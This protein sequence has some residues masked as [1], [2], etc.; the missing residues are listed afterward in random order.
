M[1]AAGT[2]VQRLE[3][4]YRV[5][6]SDGG[7]R[8]GHSRKRGRTLAAFYISTLCA[9]G[10]LVGLSLA[11]TRV[12]A[13]QSYNVYVQPIFLYQFA[14]SNTCSVDC[15]G[16][17]YA[18]PSA[19]TDAYN[20]AQSVIE[21]QHGQGEQNYS[22]V[23]LVIPPNQLIVDGY[24][25]TYL[26]SVEDCPTGGSC[27]NIPDAGSINLAWT[28]P[29]NWTYGYINNGQ[30]PQLELCYPNPPRYNILPCP[31]CLG[32][33]VYPAS[34]QNI[35]PETDYQGPAVNFTRTYRSDTGRFSSIATQAFVNNSGPA[36]TA[37]ERCYAGSWSYQGQTGYYC[38]PYE[39]AYPDAGNGPQYQ[40]VTDDGRT[41]LFTG[42][43]SAITQNADIN[44]RITQITVNGAVEWQIH[45]EDD[46]IE[47]Y[48]AGG[49][50]LQKTLRGGQ[51]FTYTY[52]N[53]NT[54]AN[55][56]PQAGLLLSQSDAF[57]HTISWQ[58]SSASQLSQ[59]TDPAG[60]FYQYGYDSNGNLTS[61]LYPDGTSKTYWY[62]ESANTGGSN[63]PNALTGVTDESAVR[64]A[65]FKYSNP[66]SQALAVNTQEAGAVNSFSFSYN[67]SAY[68]TGAT[69]T[70]ATVVDP[71]GTSRTYDFAFNSNLT[72]NV[73][74][75]ETQ[76]AASGSGTAS[77]SKTYDA[78]YN[79]ASVT[80]FNGD[81]TTYLY[82]L[83]RNLE[84][85]RIEAH[86]TAQ[87][88]TV[89]TQWDANWRQPALI[90]LYSGG[91][92]TGTPLETTSFTYNG[93][94]GVSCGTG[95]AG[96]LC[97]K[98]ITDMTVTPNVSRTWSY[99]Y[100]SY[101]RML[102]AKGP[103]TDVNSTTT[104]TYYTCTTGYQCGE[105]DTIQDALGHTWTFNT[106]NAHGQ[107]LTVTDPNGVVT[108]LTYDQRLRVLSRQIGTET[109]RYSYWPTGLLKMVTLPDSSTVS[110]TYD[111]A[112]RLTAITDGTG[113]YVSYTLDNMG[114]HTA[115]S[116]YDPSGT[117]HRTH[118][119]V[120][121]ALNELYQDINSAGTAAVTTTYGYD[122]DGNLT[123]SDAPLSRN[124][125]NQY[126]ALNRLT[127]ITDPNSGVTQLGYD[128]NDNLASVIDPRTL[129]TSYTHNGFGDVI[130]VVSPDTGKTVSTYDSGGD[131]KTTTDARSDLATYSYDA[132]NRVTQVAYSD[133]TINYTYDTGTNGK[134]HLTGASDASHSMSWTYDTLG[135][136]NGKGQTVG[137]LT[138]SVGYS[139]T[140]SDLITLVTP[141]GQTVTYTYTNHRITSIK[142]GS[143]TLLS[144]VT[145]DP[146]GPA[147]GWTWGNNT[148]S[149]R[150][151]TEDG[152]PNQ[153]TTA[154][155]INGYTEDNA[156]RITGISDSGLSSNTFT[157]GYDLL[158][159]VNSA[160]SSA[161][162]RG[163]QYD[164]NGN[165][166]LETGSV[167]YTP[168]ISPINNQVA[169][170][171]GGLVR[172][173]AYD[174]AGNTT[175]YGNNVYAFN[176]RGRM[177]S[178]TVSGSQTTYIYN[179]L[180]QLVQKS[181]STGATNLVYD[182]AGH[183]LGEYSTSGALIQETIWMED[184]PVA[185][186]RP[187]GS[188]ISIYY[189]HTDHLGTPRKV[190]QPSNNTLAWR[191]DP[192]TYGSVS[193]NQNPGGLGTFV[194][195]LR[196]PGQYYQTET[197]LFYNYFRDYDPQTGRYLESDP[198]GLY[199]G[200][201]S[202]Y[203]YTNNNP[204]SNSDPSGLQA[205]PVPLPLPLY[206]PAAPPG[207]PLNNAIY[208]FLEMEAQGATN[209]FDWA[210]YLSSQAGNAVG[211][212]LDNIML[213]A[214]GGK[215]NISNEYSR[216]ARN[217]ND[218]CGWLSEQYDMARKAG[219]S[220]AAQKI[221]Q[222][223]KDLGCRNKAKRCP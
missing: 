50:L 167:A 203:S 120:F 22:D 37:G 7:S 89:T 90:S 218:P 147:T 19:L 47:I 134:G 199:G 92:A 69:V 143:T 96:A 157:F 17:W 23:Q 220:A 178:A 114:N 190:T 142:V 137:G 135:R 219:D 6:R 79:I 42:P 91:A 73:E 208:N 41:L 213:M 101:G 112:H 176:D 85:Q 127:K 81:V 196:F 124:T 44:D 87:A 100:D 77:L 192:D 186:L 121:N 117:L 169:S 210:N 162:A 116:A 34:G 119:R 161:I 194:Y 61:V 206:V 16:P 55:I 129:T 184:L 175:G 83:T 52:S 168:T 72:H 113:N 43:N 31:F 209:L 193:P 10:L 49:S 88:R 221:I 65:T 139:Y 8:L 133:Q 94:A 9:L 223:Q 164:A 99:T 60:K 202:T 144:G 111:G 159:R 205:L 26:L 132:L 63:L 13:Q 109:T 180:G 54:P 95:A 146:F 66:Y 118:T 145:Y 122:N 187:N 5:M 57:G 74:T 67:G 68:F 28:C 172:T 131:L 128:A 188:S 1:R 56:A 62:N 51:S 215:Q 45:R 211:G 103:R 78:N 207:S 181:N 165:T 214:K 198:I 97:S 86:G 204:I 136:V 216:A 12:K 217:Q 173:Y 53:A 64:Y 30:T 3:R 15:T 29:A 21:A 158:D 75:S 155:V 4:I 182:E 125:S 82:D 32:D 2:K 108:T 222:A 177:K 58:Y 35:E 156:L 110:Y 141:S 102:T 149:T 197:G 153:I 84:I 138:K 20:N 166:T 201:Y 38:Y 191:W 33:P 59:M 104:Y 36:G 148:S 105:V 107:P 183:L 160:A 93:D 150:T 174:A 48:D 126:D 212:A 171:K 98:T 115:E 46:S 140:N 195:N 106:Y 11:P 185:T 39:S 24:V 170:T 179:T 14:G 27:Y 200:S 123:S 152:V 18:G 71:L 163:Y 80:D 151:Y 25:T 130:Q 40:L 154:G 76:P 189:V 70:A